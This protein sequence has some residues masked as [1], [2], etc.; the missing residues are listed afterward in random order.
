[1]QLS[2]N[3]KATLMQLKLHK[4]CDGLKPSDALFRDPW[5]V[6]N[7]CS[8]VWCEEMPT[9]PFVLFHVTSESWLLSGD[10]S[11]KRL[12]SKEDFLFPL[13]YHY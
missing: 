10:G 1:M 13:H 3:L 2:G 4:L 9:Q 6:R 11:N 8:H 5:F 12:L 7:P